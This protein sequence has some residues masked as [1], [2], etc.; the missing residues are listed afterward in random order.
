[1]I[2]QVVERWT[3][4]SGVRIR[5]LDNA[6]PDP[7]GLPILFSPGLSDF[8]DEYA[9]VLEFF[10]PRRVFVVEVRGRGQSEAPASGYAVSDH[11]RDL[12]A[13]LEEEGVGDVHVMTFS[14]GTSWALE[15][16]LTEP[17]RVASLSIGDYKAFELRLT[18]E[19][20]DSQMQSRFRG[21]PMTERLSRHVLDGLAAAS[22]G[23]E[24]WDRLSELPC[25]LLV[26]QPGSGQGLVNDDVVAMYRAARP[27]VEVVIVPD[28]P[29][30]IFRPDRL[31]Y[32][33]A[34]AEFIA[35]RCPGR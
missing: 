21:K 4:R 29:H 16:A 34:V 14:R 19:F 20:V 13:V 11:M 10:S 9:E 26:A 1:M 30:D 23:R 24:L 27:D 25:P 28:A 32:P 33:R 35:R 22:Q 2:S 3:E 6:P 8:A 12:Q 18:Q 5:Y 17:D 31:F 15:L 7:T